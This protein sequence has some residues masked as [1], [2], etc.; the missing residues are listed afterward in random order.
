MDT[1]ETLFRVGLKKARCSIISIKWIGTEK[2]ISE[3]LMVFFFSPCSSLSELLQNITAACTRQFTCR[4]NNQ[5]ESQDSRGNASIVLP[6][7]DP[8]LVLKRFDM[9][10]TNNNNSITQ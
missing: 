8:C 9:D 7:I 3:S 1:Q 2:R 6:V 4:G 10:K 5:W